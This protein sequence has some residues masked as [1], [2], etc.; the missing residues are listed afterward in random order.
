MVCFM[1]VKSQPATTVVNVGIA[2][3]LVNN[4]VTILSVSPLPF[5]EG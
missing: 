5:K 2:R 3:E 4:A 1:Y